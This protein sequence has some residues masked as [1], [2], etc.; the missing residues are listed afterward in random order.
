MRFLFKLERQLGRYAF[1]NLTISLVAVQVSCLLIGLSNPDVWEALALKPNL[2]F[3]GEVWRLATFLCD[4]PVKNILFAIFFFYIFYLMGT[5][6]EAQWGDF[7]YNLYLL[8]GYIANVSVALLGAVFLP[9][10][11]VATNAFLQGTVFLAFAH[12]YPDFEL[13]LFFI[14]PVKVKWLALLAWIGYGLGFVG[15]LA[16]FADGGWL[17]S[18]TALTSVI[19]FFLFF[20]DEF[21]QRV[22]AV[23][24]KREWESKIRRR[25]NEA[26]HRCTV[27]G[28]TNISHPQ[29]DFRYCTQ[30]EGSH[31]YCT[32][33]IRQHEHVTVDQSE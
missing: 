21:L 5:A 31:G 30:C 22:A 18:L 12:L 8:I 7:R 25:P 33:H 4:P 10:D 29:M 6:L 1:P 14:L 3:E 13:M 19:N 16:N 27:C 26:R 2:V 15:G 23:R 17:I 24:R 9:G 28:I 11:S 32:E 20:G